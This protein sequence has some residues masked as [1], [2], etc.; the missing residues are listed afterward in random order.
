MAA[1]LSTSSLGRTPRFI[2]EAPATVAGGAAEFD[3]E[4]STTYLPHV[5]LPTNMYVGEFYSQ[6]EQKTFTMYADTVD[7]AAAWKAMVKI[8]AQNGDLAASPSLGERLARRQV[9]PDILGKATMV[10]GIAFYFTPRDTQE[11]EARPR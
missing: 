3:L 10:D 1:C 6:I 8:R 2:S 7:R 11:F 4:S 5:S 9:N